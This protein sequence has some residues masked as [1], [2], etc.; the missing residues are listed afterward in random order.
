MNPVSNIQ[1]FT[2]LRGKGSVEDIV[3][4]M[5]PVRAA[6]T[7]KAM[8]MAREATTA[9]SRHHLTGAA[10]INVT[11]A[12][13]RT[14]DVYVELHDRDP[15]GVGARPGKDRSAASIEFGWEGHDGLHILGNVMKR[16]IGRARRS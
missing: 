7:G 12:P 2:P 11:L 16:A 1:W 5:A 8:G 13:P 4:H 15:G 9:L 3:S 14:L 10:H 6:V